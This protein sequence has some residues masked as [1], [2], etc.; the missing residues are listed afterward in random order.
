[1]LSNEL[2]LYDTDCIFLWLDQLNQKS[3]LLEFLLYCP[4]ELDVGREAVAFGYVVVFGALQHL[5]LDALAEHAS[6][7]RKL[8]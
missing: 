5:S 8:N 3:L 1:M 6:L 7:Q 4:D 2:L